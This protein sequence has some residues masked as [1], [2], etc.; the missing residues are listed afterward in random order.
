MAL[1][2]MKRPR[3]AILKLPLVEA[4]QVKQRDKKC[5]TGAYI[6]SDKLVVRLGGERIELPVP[7]RTVHWLRDKEHEVAPL[8]VHKTVRIQWREDRDP[9]TLRVQ[10]VLRVRRPRPPRPD[11]KSALLVH[12]DVNSAYGI[13]LIFASY[14]DGYAKIHETLKLRPPNRG[15]RLKEA[16]KRERAAAYGSK[17][18]KNRA[19]A[20]LTMKFDAQGWVKAAAEI[21]KKAMKRARGR[22]VWINIDALDSESVKRSRLQRTFS[23][24]RV[25]ENLA[26]WYGVYATS[27]CYPSRRC[28]TCGGRLKE[29]RTKRARIAR[30]R[31]CG[32]FDD[33]VRPLLLVGQGTGPAT[34][35]WPLRALKLPEPNDL[36][37]L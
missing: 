23:I 1:E 20:R 34:A 22:S 18:N 33:R 28:P 30:C 7:R 25:A 3:K 16:A 13:A 19:L 10:I 2:K 36:E 26:N 4:L 37:A 29:L 9:K 8:K 35:E 17:P 32:F 15:R 6:Y 27:E 5:A 24:R 11:P 21:L 14:E 31:Q 12:V